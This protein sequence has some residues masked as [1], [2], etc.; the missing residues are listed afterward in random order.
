MSDL[1]K[2]VTGRGIREGPGA[3]AEMRGLKNSKET[4]LRR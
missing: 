3:E 2:S 4:R 1:G